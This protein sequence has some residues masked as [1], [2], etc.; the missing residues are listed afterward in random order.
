MTDRFV[1]D[2]SSRNQMKND[3]RSY[4]RNFCTCVKKPEKKFRTSTGP[5]ILFYFFQASLR[6]CKNCDHNCE[7]HSSFDFISPVHI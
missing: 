1:F 7:D 3:P 6:N 4:D 5:E 2:E